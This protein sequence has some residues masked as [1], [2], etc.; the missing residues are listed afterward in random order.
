MLF[1]Q[2]HNELKRYSEGSQMPSNKGKVVH[3]AV[4]KGF[5]LSSF[6]KTVMTDKDNV[7]RNYVKDGGY[8]LQKLN[9]RRDVSLLLKNL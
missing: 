1:D 7:T 2:L 5:P 3:N 9:C 8:T 4:S 6:V